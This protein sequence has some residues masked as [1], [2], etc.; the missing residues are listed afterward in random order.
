MHSSRST[1]SAVAAG[2]AALV[3][4]GLAA[5]A[6]ALTA[7]PAP[8]RAS[9]T[10]YSPPRHVAHFDAT[11]SPASPEQLRL[12]VNDDERVHHALTLVAHHHAPFLATAATGRHD[13][14]TL[15]LVPRPHPY[16][17]D[18]LVRRMPT[19][20]G[21]A[22][23][24]AVVLRY[25]LLVA[26]GATL[27]IDSR[28]V[29][30][31]L[32]RS[33]R[34]G[35]APITAVSA[36]LDLRGHPGRPLHVASVDLTKGGPDTAESD[37][38]AYL[39]DR[40]GTMTLRATKLS[41]LGYAV[42]RSSGVAWLGDGDR[43]ATGGASW[44]TFSHNHFGAAGYAAQGLVVSHS[45]FLDNDLYG[46]D[47]HDG[48]T[49]SVIVDSVAAH[50][51]RHGFILSRGC[52]DN[53][54]RDDEAYDNGGAGFVIDDGHVELDGN[55]RHAVADPSDHNRLLDVSS[56]DNGLVGITVEGGI[57]NAVEGSH[58]DNNRYGLW[59]KNGATATVLTGDTVTRS[60][61]AGIR[62]FPGTRATNLADSTVSGAL[63]GIAADDS[64]TAVMTD[65]RV[66][67]AQLNALRFRGAHTTDV[68]TR[69]IASGDG[70]R[71][72]DARHASL[73]ATQQ[74]AIDET[75]WRVRH[76]P[77]SVAHYLVR[78]ANL[79]AWVP[80]VVLPLLFWIPARHRRRVAAARPVLVR[81]A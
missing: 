74:A 67:A 2:A 45:A 77:V 13:A 14:L 16:Q 18:N 76:V 58:V 7:A 62:L 37:G 52:H 43:P 6:W 55:P 42:G 15:V 44:S 60:L 22:A 33:D 32:L 57:G 47:P 10:S 11:T 12:V 41:Y 3:L 51:G 24:G 70:P 21:H 8:Q 25:P 38:R 64:A 81:A 59:V 36:T 26:P 53:L 39:Q 78:H 9:A 71:A 28:T 68:L 4:V 23:A 75:G 30:S 54:L 79:L 35:Y 27:V 61:L 72:V 29:P 73:T 50:N 65:V 1:R 5:T 20:F 40:G 63:I 49:H 69:V 66:V 56:H 48:T 80:I 17:L 19:A 31:L 46:F 34:T